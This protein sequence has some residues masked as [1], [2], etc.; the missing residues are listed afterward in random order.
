MAW[1]SFFFIQM[2][3]NMVNNITQY[4]FLINIGPI[5]FVFHVH[6]TTYCCIKRN[7]KMISSINNILVANKK[8]LVFYS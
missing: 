1:L 5:F 4:S 2:F 6:L 8:Q 3:V 7:E